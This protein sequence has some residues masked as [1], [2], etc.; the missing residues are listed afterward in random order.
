[1]KADLKDLYIPLGIC[2]TFLVALSFPLN[3]GLYEFPLLL[4]PLLALILLNLE[5][6]VSLKVMRVEVMLASLPPLLLALSLLLPL[7][8]SSLT[9][10][11]FLML[12]FIPLAPLVS[13][14]PWESLGLS[15][16][17]GGLTLTFLMLLNM[18]VRLPALESIVTI[19]I[20]ICLASLY[21]ILKGRSLWRDLEFRFDNYVALTLLLAAFFLLELALVY[22]YIFML[23]TNDVLYHQD[24]AWEL[25]RR[26]GDYHG[27]SY[28]G[29]HSLLGTVYLIER[30]D[31]FSVMLTAIPLNL[32][33]FL[34]VASSFSKLRS[35]GEALLT[36]SLFT[37][38]A[39]LAVIRYGTSYDMLEK[40]NEASYRSLIWSQPVF[41]WGLP[42][43]TAIGLLAFLLYSDLYVEGRRKVLYVFSS[44]SLAFLLHVAEALVF[45]AYLVLVSLLLGRRRHSALG[46]TLA[47]LLLYSLY[48]IPGI[49]EGAPAS[50]SLYLLISGAL[51]LILS[52]LRGRYLV[53]PLTRF[54]RFISGGRSVMISALLA[55]Y[56]AGLI[57]W[58]LHL[59]EVNVSELFYLGHVPW[60]LYPNL[61]G[62]AG[63]LGILSLNSKMDEALKS[64]VLFILTSLLLGR[65]VTYL[66]LSVASFS[67]WEYRFP[68]Y[69]ALGLA[70]LSSLLLRR[71]RELSRSSK[72][73]AI[74]LAG[75]IVTGFS[76]T[77]FSI[78]LWDQLSERGSGAISTPDLNLAITG[79]LRADYPLLVLSHYS[80]TV[81][82]LMHARDVMMQ[83]SVWIAKGPE[84]PLLL[85]SDLSRG[86]K[87]AVLTTL[88]DLAFLNGENATYNYLFMFLGPIPS[89]PSLKILNLSK[90]PVPNASV[91]LI[92]PSD[93]YFMR[94]SLI[95]YELVRG[96]LPIHSIYLSDDPGAPVGIC[97]GPSSANQTIDEELP[98]ERADLRWLYLRGNFSEVEGGLR[99][100]AT[101]NIAITTYEL[102]RG[103]LVLNA[104][105]D[106]AGYVGIIYEFENLKNYRIFQVYLDKGVAVNRVVRGGSVS[107]G[108]PVPVPLSWECN[109]IR[110][111]LGDHLEASVNGRV[112]EL[113]DVGGLGVLGFE[114]GN[115]TGTISGKVSGSHS[116]IWKDDLCSL[117]LDV[118]GELREWVERGLRNLTEAKR[119]FPGLKISVSGVE[120]EVP[121]IKA[122]ITGLK[123]SGSVKIS[124]RPV[125]IMKEGTKTYLNSTE[126]VLR[127]EKLEYLRGDGFYADLSLEGVPGMS[128][129]VVRFRTPV[130][131]EASGEVKLERYHAFQRSVREA[132]DVSTSEANL[133]LIAADRAILLSELESPEKD[134]SE[135]ELLF[136]TFDETKYLPETLASFLPLAL[137]FYRTAA[138]SERAKARREI[139]VKRR[140]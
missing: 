122:I 8:Y 15:F 116:L 137:V 33:S 135:R 46:V 7:P 76:S 60:F 59:G 95:A 75:L 80:S 54:E 101:R 4:V 113:P 21:L 45:S 97:I 109:E 98:R 23:T 16:S 139:G 74:L 64:Y 3:L 87:V 20:V 29:F 47:G 133:T 82:S 112:I 140:K 22:P 32:M 2:L 36:W 134:L 88:G 106:L 138:R 130:R 117:K 107:S 57:V 119:M 63:L 127:A 35:R 6:K 43:T 58:Q 28:L 110:L 118:S 71:M 14:D 136:K 67:Y 41:F 61:L 37:S 1:M 40:A 96:D 108:T 125:W 42:L 31:P 70:V 85:L 104:C 102:D 53:E 19:S 38:L 12:M 73:Q 81:S 123:V 121:R 93:V 24:A 90:P 86:D 115:F 52:E 128:S 105:G 78:Q 72:L 48:L 120:S 56:S 51:S 62:I 114:T 39:S 11:T 89:V 92:L 99:V 69:A 83:P 79:D 26:P 103:E 27:W 10:M 17:L 50:T 100:R 9:F 68:L 49:Y 66:K 129:L 132:R 94:R 91:S 77:A 65:A 30:A 34:I 13:G 18:S 84:V 131:I 55:L 124:G 25:A 111:R 44:T 126:L 5:F